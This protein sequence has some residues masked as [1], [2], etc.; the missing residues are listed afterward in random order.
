MKLAASYFN[1]IPSFRSHFHY[2]IMTLKIL[3]RPTILDQLSYFKK[4]DLNVSHLKTI[5][6]FTVHKPNFSSKFEDFTLNL[7]SIIYIRMYIIRHQE[8]IYIFP[9]D[10]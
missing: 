2:V 8:N 4:K 9:E 5:A 3:G 10:H 6:D 7:S 1:L